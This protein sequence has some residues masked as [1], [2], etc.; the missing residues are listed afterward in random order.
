MLAVA[1]VLETISFMVGYRAYRRVVRGRQVDGGE[2]GLWRFIEL[3][4]GSN[5]YESLLEDLAALVGLGI[6][7]LGVAAARSTANG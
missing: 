7:A 4:Q 6:A 1:A 2:I 5:L 3:S